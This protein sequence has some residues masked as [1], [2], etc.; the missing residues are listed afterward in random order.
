MVLELWPCAD[1]GSRG[2]APKPSY[3]TAAKR[4]GC[5]PEQLKSTYQNV[6][7]KVNVARPVGAKISDFQ[8]LG[9]YL[10]DVEG[11]IGPDDLPE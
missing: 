1:L 3:V 7:R 8:E 10:I 5:T 11:L 6:M 9:L 2:R 4:A